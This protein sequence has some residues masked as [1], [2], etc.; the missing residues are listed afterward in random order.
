MKE[1]H[2]GG[3]PTKYKKKYC[4]EIIEYFE[5]ESTKT[6]Y[7][8]EYYSDGDI[9]KVK[10][11]VTA[12][13]IP[14]FQGFAHKIGVNMDTLTEWNSVHEEF[15]V[16]YK[17]AKELQ[18]KIWLENSMCGRYSPQFAIFFGKNCLGYKDKQEVE[19]SGT[20]KLEDVL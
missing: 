15:S 8:K 11:I 12:N 16:A 17:K 6:E 3:R 19:H 9:K 7:E 13:D 14:T 18:E 5:V 2:P 10:P 4:K 1:K 20:L